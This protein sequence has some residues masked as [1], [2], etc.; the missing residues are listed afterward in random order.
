MSETE[1]LCPAAQEVFATFPVRKNAAQKAAFRARLGEL[2][3]ADGWPVQTEH[4]GKVLKTNNVVAGNPDTARLVLTAHYDTPARMPFPNFIA[5]R[6][7]AAN[8]LYQLALVAVVFI[9][10]FC[11]SFVVRHLGGSGLW[12]S[13]ANLVFLLL[14]LWLLMAGPANPHNANDNTSG[15]LTLLE[16]AHA[17]PKE[18]Q[19]HVA[20]VFFDNEELGLVGSGTFCVRHPK[21]NRVPLL[22]FDC[23]GNGDTLLFVLPRAD[24]KNAV[25][26]DALKAAFPEKDNNQAIIDA[27]P[28]TIYPSDQLHFT[29]GVGVA[30]MISAPLVGYYLPWLHTPRDTVLQQENLLYLR[31]G[32][33]ALLSSWPKDGWK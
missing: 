20:L 32:C 18:Q 21:V 11:V 30:A 31:S 13:A 12:L 10:S 23:V 5:P 27:S 14:F 2:L 24:R 28:L 8:I 17:L 33:L 4:S 9:L 3:A 29:R 1:Q 22:N 6:N 16:M 19:Q 15:V 25:W 26:Q 7:L